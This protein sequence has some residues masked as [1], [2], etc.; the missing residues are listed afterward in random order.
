MKF[1]ALSEQFRKNIQTY[2]IIIFLV[3]IWGVFAIATKGGYFSPQNISNLFRQMTVT[4]FLA[5]GMVLVMVT[6]GIDLSVGKLAG[7][8]SVIVAL[9]QRDVWV[10][11]IPGHPILAALF[12]V[13]VGLITG[14]LF[15]VFQ[16]Y[17]TAYL[18]VPF[19]YRHT[20]WTVHPQWRYFTRHR[21]SNH[22][23]E[24]TGLQL[25]CTGLPA[26]CRRLDPWDCCGHHPV[27]DDVYESSHK[28]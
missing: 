28:S 22:C 7:F 18:R 5:A 3:L 12:S 26:R 24:P 23:G 14:S 25:H 2:I 16:A 15:G 8:V 9:F 20:G 4:G 21:R 11:I 6:G 27:R 19:L 17:I 1:S 10:H 13:V